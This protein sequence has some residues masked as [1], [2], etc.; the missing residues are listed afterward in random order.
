[1]VASTD[2]DTKQYQESIQS[3]ELTPIPQLQTIANLSHS[4]PESQLQDVKSGQLTV[5]PQ[6]QNVQWAGLPP[7]PQVQSELVNVIPG[8]QSRVMEGVHSDLPQEV[9]EDIK[10]VA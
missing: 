9:P 3:E 10:M 4:V 2:L 7:N 8:S 6:L 1:M 5:E